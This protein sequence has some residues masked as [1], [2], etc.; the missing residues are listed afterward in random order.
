[1]QIT[2][3]FPM[4]TSGKAAYKADEKTSCPNANPPEPTLLEAVEAAINYCAKA[5]NTLE[6]K[7]ADARK[8]LCGLLTLKEELLNDK[9][10]PSAQ[11]FLFNHLE[12]N[13]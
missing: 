13:L 11:K 12:D 9:S 1:M 7:T 2:T 4:H 3:E 10:P 5:I 6:V 8:D